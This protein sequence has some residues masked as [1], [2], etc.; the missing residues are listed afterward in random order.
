MSFDTLFLIPS[1]WTEWREWA[2]GDAPRLI[3][4]VIGLVVAYLAFRFAVGRLLRAMISRAAALRRE[5]PFAVERRAQTLVST[6]NWL[7]T[8]FLAFIGAVLVLDNLE[9]NVGALIAGVG[10]AGVAVG[11]GA[12]TLI[13]DII[14]GTLIL[15]EGQYLVGDVVTVAGVSGEVIEINPRRTVLRDAD[16]SVHTI[17]NSAI[18]VATNQT[19]GF[20]RILLDVPVAYGADLARACE[21][22]R[23]EYLELGRTFPG[24]GLTAPRVV[25]VQSLLENHA[26]LRVSGD[27]RVG[28]Q[29]DLAAELRGAVVARFAREGIPL[30]AP[31]VAPAAPQ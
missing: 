29:W 18:S 22:L 13:R 21:L 14:N 25:R 20:S 28:R 23:E 16:G 6:L 4:I 8:T 15:V 12:Q 1:N 19:Q 11:L 9:V 17:P 3:P 24:E 7:F 10:I 5:E 27:V 30:V 31:P 2:R 26:V